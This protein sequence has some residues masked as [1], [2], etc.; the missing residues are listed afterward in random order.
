MNRNNIEYM[1]DFKR[2]KETVPNIIVDYIRSSLERG[3]LKPGDQILSEIDIAEL[4]SVSR[5]SVREAMKI[6]SV[7]GVVEIRRGKGTFISD[8]ID[9]KDSINPL[10]FNF[11]LL[12]PNQKEIVDYRCYI[13]RA[14]FEAAIKNATLKE[15]EMLEQNLNIL[16]KIKKPSKKTLELEIEFHQILG[17][18]TKNKL[19]TKTY[20][21]AMDYFKPSIEITHYNQ[22]NL[23]ETVEIHEI[24]IRV[25]KE[26][27]FDMINLVL[28][29]NIEIWVR[30]SNIN[31]NNY[32]NEHLSF[33]KRG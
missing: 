28:E 21:I 30:L 29:K 5:S 27:N 9:S 13:E 7:Y 14:V 10:L 19:M 22:N 26:R 32:M 31:S 25:L 23:E 20:E 2:T 8:N 33:R 4:L 6:L 18:C 12:K 16:R 15:I 17:R 3:D 24:S 1:D 11:I